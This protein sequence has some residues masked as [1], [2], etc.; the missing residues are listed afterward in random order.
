MQHRLY[1]LRGQDYVKEYKSLY[2][3][4][5]PEI[6]K[7][8]EALCQVKGTFTPED[9]GKIVIKFQFPVKVMVEYLE[10]YGLLPKGTWTK[11]QYRGFKAKD[12]GVVWS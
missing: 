12:I 7:E 2:Q 8:F 11:L 5:Q 4:L 9:L 1:G 10:G 6:T 3:E